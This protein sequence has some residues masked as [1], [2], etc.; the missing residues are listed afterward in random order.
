MVGSG[1]LLFHNSI[2]IM[3]RYRPMKKRMEQLKKARQVRAEKQKEK[4]ETKRQEAEQQTDAQPGTSA[5]TAHEPREEQPRFKEGG[6]EEEEG[7]EESIDEPAEEQQERTETEGRLDEEEREEG[8][9]RQQEA[10]R[11]DEEQRSGEE[12]IEP[13]PSTS[14]DGRAQDTI[15]PPGTSAD[16]GQSP[17]L[18][19]REMRK[20]FAKKIARPQDR[21]SY[22][23]M[24]KLQVEKQYY[25]WCRKCAKDAKMNPT[26]SVRYGGAHKMQ[27][28][29]G[30]CKNV[31]KDWTSYTNKPHGKFDVN[32]KMVEF[33]LMNNGYKTL[34]DFEKVFETKMLTAT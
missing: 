4:R 25:S 23:M 28:T 13:Q 14:R 21:R 22:I 3:P 26:S 10:G 19:K 34:Q 30:K 1:L 33:C 6:R 17:A 18:V 16:F 32:V 29:C 27:V 2:G 24:D 31:I 9:G 5:G 8:E 11:T 15:A 20:E 12:S 7:S